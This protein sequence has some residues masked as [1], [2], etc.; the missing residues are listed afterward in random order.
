MGL[1]TR[2]QHALDQTR[3]VT[4]AEGGEGKCGEK[5]GERRGKMSTDRKRNIMLGDLVYPED[6][7]PDVVPDVVPGVI[8]VGSVTRLAKST[9][10]QS[11]FGE[12]DDPISFN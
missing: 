9:W 6:A 1:L 3:E 11:R 4:R 2:F 8:L 12:A 10:F 7:V 5:K